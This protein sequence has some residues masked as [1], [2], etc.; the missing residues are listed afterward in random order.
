MKSILPK[1]SLRLLSILPAI[2]FIN[3]NDVNAQAFYFGADLSYVNEMEDCGANYTSGGVSED[4]Y[5]IFSEHGAN[6][7][8]L[9][10]WHTPSWY[11]D[12]NQGYR[13]SDLQDVRHSIMRA[14][15]LGMQV[16]LDFQLSDTW[17]DPGKQVIPAAWAP[18][19]DSL[20]ILKDSLYNYIFS[21]L[22]GLANENL[23]PEL[24]QIGNETNKGILVSQETNDGG[25]TLSWPRN[26][27]LF[28]IAI[29]AVRDVQALHST[30]IK[31]A[32]HIAGP[33]NAGWLMEG[34]W[35]HGV[36]DFD[37]IG[38]SYYW[39]Y[40][41][42]LLEDVG[43]TITSLKS[44]YPGKDVMILETGYP[45]TTSNADVANNLLYNSYPGYG[46]PSPEHQKQWLT[47]LTQKVIDHGG[48][49]VIYWEPAWISTNCSTR[50]GVGSNWDNA[51]FFD[52][53]EEVQEN[54]GI[55][56]MSYNYD[57]TL[58]VEPDVSF[59]KHLQIFQRGNEIILKRNDPDLFNSPFYVELIT[60]E[61]R[62][63]NSFCIDPDWGN[64]MAQILIHNS[65][66]GICFVS[67]KSKD[68]TLSKVFKVI[69][70]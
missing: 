63:V 16:L 4:P 52:H 58:A 13:Y 34:F 26:A 45:W 48:K 15:T 3:R 21:T 69:I 38:L 24:V 37:I 53:N 23:L 27:A 11:D 2:F 44:V 10:L 30:Q 42:V 17:A 62:I 31:I 9:R 6:L 65:I 56:W 49:G 29:K 12:L 36:R 59:P 55:G 25:F 18:V 20:E 46:P 33:A 67:L 57:F 28:N 39:Q 8:R 68:N 1:I 22:D 5:K 19:V 64:N 50:F 35:S 43:N 41:M 14:K 32:L 61:G 60:I 7:V 54:G 51:T 70:Y 66:P 47:D 40:H